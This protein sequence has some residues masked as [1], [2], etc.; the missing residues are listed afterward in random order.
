MTTKS[1]LLA[2]LMLAFAWTAIAGDVSGKWTAQVP[3]RDGQTR[4]QTFQFKQ[5]GDKLTGTATLFQGNE[6]PITDGKVS[7]DDI[8]FAIKAEFNGNSFQMNYKGKVS[9][10]EIKMTSQR[11]GGNQVREFTAKK[12]K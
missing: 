1:L 11:E 9:G 10:E 7:G 8:S 6:L 2:V 12:A 4:E 3:G 5:E